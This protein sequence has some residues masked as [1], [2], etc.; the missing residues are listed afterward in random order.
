[1]GL[2]D[3]QLQSDAAFLMADVDAVPGSEAVTYTKPDGTT[4]SINAVVNRNPP[5]RITPNGEMVT[6]SML[7]TVAN[8][9]TYG[10]TSAEVDARGADKITLPERM[11]Q[12]AKAF[13]VYVPDAGTGSW[14]N[15]GFLTLELR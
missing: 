8:D 6:V 15:A 14:H 2:L 3:T 12:T 11:G 5:S 7:V 13:S 1:M 9:A 10:I 4:R